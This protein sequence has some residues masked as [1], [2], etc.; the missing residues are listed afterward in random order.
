MRRPSCACYGRPPQAPSPAAAIQKRNSPPPPGKP[1]SAPVTRDINYADAYMRTQSLHWRLY[2]DVFRALYE[3]DGAKGVSMPV[4]KYQMQQIFQRYAEQHRRPADGDAPASAADANSSFFTY[5][6]E[7]SRMAYYMYRVPKHAV[8]IGKCLRAGHDHIHRLL[9]QAAAEGQPFVVASFG[10][11]PGSDFFGFLA[12]LDRTGWLA[13]GNPKRPPIIFHVFDMGPW[14]DIWSH[15][16]A[17]LPRYYPSVK[18]HFHTVDL[19]APDSARRVPPETRVLLF[20]YFIVEMTPFAD[21]FTAFFTRL[22][23][24]VHPGA[25]FVA[26][27]SQTDAAVALRGRLTAAAGLTVVLKQSARMCLSYLCIMPQ[28][29]R[30]YG[31]AWNMATMTP[32]LEVWQVAGAEGVGRAAKVRRFLRSVAAPPATLD[33]ATASDDSS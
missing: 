25:C 33:D 31:L 9:T 1:T 29:R 10:G 28:N 32:Q 2:F 14:V 8:A 4:L 13:R 26:I 5:D 20:S 23:G 21:Q 17:A 7:D 12:Y 22:V 3:P 15:V 19:A 18:V 6:D 16:T 30:S 27:D 11:G 24:T